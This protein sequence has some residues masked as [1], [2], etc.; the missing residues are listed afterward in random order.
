MKLVSGDPTWRNLTALDYHFW[1]QPLP[2]PFAWHAV[3]LPHW[4]LVSATAM[5]LAIELGLVFLIFLP[6]RLRAIAAWGVLGAGRQTTPR[7]QPD[8]G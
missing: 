7:W 6:R 4:V 1:T 3:Q 5:V 8:H 2:T